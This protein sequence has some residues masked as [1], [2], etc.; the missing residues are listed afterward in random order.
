MNCDCCSADAE[1]VSAL[2]FD[3]AKDSDEIR[4]ESENRLEELENLS[5]M[6]KDGT[7]SDGFHTFKELYEFRML[8]HAIAAK[9]WLESGAHVVKS[10]KH[11]DGEL[12][13]GGGWFVVSAQLKS[14]QVT[15][16]YEDKHWDLFKI[17]EVDT[18]PEWDGHDSSDVLSR[19]MESLAEDDH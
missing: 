1:V 16:H 4:E 13:F 14:G 18:P 9:H 17:P 7:A 15:N 5:R 2:C 6:V 10:R 11:S 8:Y 19:L 12:C 3:C